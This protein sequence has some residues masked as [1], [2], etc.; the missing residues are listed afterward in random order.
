[1]LSTVTNIAMYNMIHTT[2]LLTQNRNTLNNIP[3]CR[4]KGT[5]QLQGC[6]WVENFETKCKK[7][8]TPL[9]GIIIEIT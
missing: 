5:H 2:H 4:R 8:T 9:E 1:M 6:R 7:R 3:A